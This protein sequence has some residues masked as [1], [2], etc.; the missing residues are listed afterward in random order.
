MIPGAGTTDEKQFYTY[1]D[2]T[3][4]PNVVYYYQL[5][6]VSVDGTRWALTRPTRLKGYVGGSRHFEE[7]IFWWKNLNQ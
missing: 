5:E 6:C 3:A 2:K 1:T 7:D 4:K